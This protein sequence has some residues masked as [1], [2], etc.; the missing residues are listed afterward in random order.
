[1]IE[2]FGDIVKKV[3]ID[4][5]L[6]NW[7]KEEL[8]ESHKDEKKYHNSQIDNLRKQ[9]VKYKNRLDKLYEDKLDGIITKEFFEEKNRLWSREQ[10]DILSMIEKNKNANANYFDQDIKILKLTQ[11]LY[12]VYFQKNPKEKGQLVK[13]LLSNCTLNDGNLCPTYKKAL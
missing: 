8:K 7:L 4:S 1:M 12:S 9:Y 3:K 11:K 13:L 10:Q 5:N 6:L 2:K